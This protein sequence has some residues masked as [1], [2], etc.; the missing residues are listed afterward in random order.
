[1]RLL[2]L[3]PKAWRQRYEVE[4]QALLDQHEVTIGTRLD[5]L[6]GA[7]DA[8]LFDRRFAVSPTVSALRGARLGLVP[9]V[10]VVA[11]FLLSLDLY[12]D[13]T[14]LNLLGTA[15]PVSL[16]VACL[17]AGKGEAERGTGWAARLLAGGAAGAAGWLATNIVHN[18]LLL[19]DLRFAITSTVIAVQGGSMSGDGFD[20]VASRML[21]PEWL[22]PN[23][24]VVVVAGVL[25][26]VIAAAGTVL[27]GVR[28]TR[29]ATP[30]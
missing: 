1:M 10:F 9:C 15:V 22:V 19:T 27:R 18:G 13:S 23:A 7:L 8:S 2:R 16:A 5:L 6:R 3:Y 26:A 25:G 4:M 14:L 21:S 20:V 28:I 17:W 29:I 12:A 11:Q 30:A 24:V